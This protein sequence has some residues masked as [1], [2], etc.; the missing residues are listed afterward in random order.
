M[1]SQLR[2]CT[3]LN[4]EK[5]CDEFINEKNKV[6]KNCVK[7]E[8]QFVTLVTNERKNKWNERTTTT[9]YAKRMAILLVSLPITSLMFHRTVKHFSAIR[10]FCWTQF[11]AHITIILRHSIQLLLL[12]LLDDWHIARDKLELIYE[13]DEI[14][15]ENEKQ[16]VGFL[17]PGTPA[18]PNYNWPNDV[19]D[20]RW[21]RACGIILALMRHSLVFCFF[22][23]SLLAVTRQPPSA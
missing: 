8:N 4:V 11:P 10:A 1:P 15:F 23:L 5:Y 20:N 14:L 17:I 3:N 19:D 12:L 22:F 16:I 9:A 7:T 2:V 18:Q 6:G 13:C 21:M